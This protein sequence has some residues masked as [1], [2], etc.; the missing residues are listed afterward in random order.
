[1]T[2]LTQS[3]LEFRQWIADMKLV[4]HVVQGSWLTWWNKQATNPIA[5][6]LDRFLVSG[7]WL[8]IFTNSVARTLSPGVSDHC[9][10]LMDSSPEV[11]SLPKP[12][13]YFKMWRQ[14]PK[15]EGLV[16]EAWDEATSGAYYKQFYRKLKFLKDKLKKLN[17]ESYSK[18]SARA[19]EA[20]LE[21]AHRQS[22][23]LL[24]PNEDNTILELEQAT[25]CSEL[26]KAEESLYR[27]KSRVRYVQEGDANTS[28]F[29][30]LVKVRNH[31]QSIKRL[32]KDDGTEVTT[33]KEMGQLQWSSI[34]NYWGTKM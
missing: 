33:V 19:R 15:Y 29:H 32:L 18:I 13:K 7:E 8:D 34:N 4:H 31:R 26:L 14:H 27:Q 3:S 9:G 5:K 20:E 12:F 1:M 25:I 17:R 11:E 28:Y 10:L 6:R 30:R 21:L 16:L 24:H 2:V 23:V 22:E